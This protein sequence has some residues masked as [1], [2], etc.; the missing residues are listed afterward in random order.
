MQ[1]DQAGWH[2]AKELKVPE[3]IRL[4]AQPAYSPEQESRGTRVGTPAR[5]AVPQFCQFLA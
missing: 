4:I 2:Q 3:N 1:V 5:K